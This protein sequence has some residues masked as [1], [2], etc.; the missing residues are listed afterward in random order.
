[1]NNYYN[2]K[3]IKVFEEKIVFLEELKVFSN[4]NFVIVE[5][6]K[7]KE[8]LEQFGIKC[9]SLKGNVDFFVEK[10]LEEKNKEEK[11]KEKSFTKKS[12]F[13]VAILTDYDFRGEKLR[14]LLKENFSLHGVEE[15]KSF[16]TKLKKL[17]KINHIE[18]LKLK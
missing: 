2:N 17:F 12:K 18:N 7:D 3:N 10:I 5:G 4:E 14:M 13:K 6:K 8:A 16:R 11:N 9:Y 1:M 15:E